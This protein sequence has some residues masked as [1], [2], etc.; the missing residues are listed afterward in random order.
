[1]IGQRESYRIAG[2]MLCVQKEQ[3]VSPSCSQKV[4]RKLGKAD[5]IVS[6]FLPSD[7]NRHMLWNLVSSL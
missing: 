4:N 2:H 5:K 3:V 6:R 7:G 1:M